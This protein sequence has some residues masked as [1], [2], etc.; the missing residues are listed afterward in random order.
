MQDYCEFTVYIENPKGALVYECSSFDSE[1][2]DI[3]CSFKKIC[4]K[5]EKKNIF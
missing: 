1:V 4:L 2:I 5:S 3:F